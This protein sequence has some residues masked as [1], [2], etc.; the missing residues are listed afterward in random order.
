MKLVY[1]F[2]SIP[3]FD[4]NCSVAIDKDCLFRTEKKYSLLLGSNTVFRTIS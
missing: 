4:T 3:V 1:L 2:G